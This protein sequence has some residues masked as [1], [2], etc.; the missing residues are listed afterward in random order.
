MRYTYV[1]RITYCMAVISDQKT[2]ALIHRYPNSV[3]TH[4]AL[5]QGKASIFVFVLCLKIMSKGRMARTEALM[6]MMKYLAIRLTRAQICPESACYANFAHT[7]NESNQCFSSQH[8]S[9]A[10]I[11]KGH[12]KGTHTPATS[13]HTYIHAQKKGRLT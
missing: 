6:I 10:I 13:S 3:F 1:D 8:F 11:H 9:K 7:S 5:T 4:T 12:A 2:N